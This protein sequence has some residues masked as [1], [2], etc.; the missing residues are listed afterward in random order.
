LKQ[1]PDQQWLGVFILIAKLELYYNMMH[2]GSHI[3]LF[4]TVQ[5][6]IVSFGL[7]QSSRFFSLSVGV[8]HSFHPVK[9]PYQGI[10]ID[11]LNTEKERVCTGISDSLGLVYFD[12]SCIV[13]DFDTLFL[14]FSVQ[15]KK[16]WME[17]ELI[18]PFLKN[19]DTRSFEFIKEFVI[20]KACFGHLDD[21]IVYSQAFSKDSFDIIN[22]EYLFS[23][24]AHYQNICITLTQTKHPDESDELAQDRILNF[25]RMLENTGI[26]TRKIMLSVESHVLSEDELKTDSRPRIEFSIGGFDCD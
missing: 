24:L 4:I 19:G 16:L 15:G 13:L 3:V 6:A 17:S 23:I 20:R 2:A 12:S 7:C 26:P 14:E 18:N 25:K 8:Y 9:N 1:T 11:L 21:F 5:I 10:Q 22:P